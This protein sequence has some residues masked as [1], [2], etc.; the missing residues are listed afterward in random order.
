MAVTLDFKLIAKCKYAATALLTFL[1]LE[2]HIAPPVTS[3][4]KCAVS[5]AFSHPV[6]LNGQAS[7]IPEVDLYRQTI[8]S[9]AI[10]A[11]EK[12]VK[13]CLH[14]ND[15]PNLNTHTLSHAHCDTVLMPYPITRLQTDDW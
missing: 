2:S 3:R 13:T 8:V 5:L 1:W 10:H 4:V 9:I 12:P 15:P 7:T 6:Q 14:I 11:K